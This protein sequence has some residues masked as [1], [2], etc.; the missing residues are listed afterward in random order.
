[1]ILTTLPRAD[2][3]PRVVLL[4]VPRPKPVSVAEAGERKPAKRLLELLPLKQ[5]PT[6]SPPEFPLPL[7]RNL[8]FFV[9]LESGLAKFTVV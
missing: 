2:A 9:P 4:T 1:M 6:L 8:T 7:N 3:P 5:T